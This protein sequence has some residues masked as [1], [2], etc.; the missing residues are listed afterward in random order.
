MAAVAPASVAPDRK[1]EYYKSDED[2]VFAVADAL[3]DEYKAIVDAGLD[4][5]GRRCRISPTSTK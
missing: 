2:Y 4:P 5:A 3:R 1:D